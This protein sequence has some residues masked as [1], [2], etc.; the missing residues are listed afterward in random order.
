M[1][2]DDFKKI[3]IEAM[4]NHDKDTVTALNAV[5]NKL[6]MESIE[7]KALNQEMTEA[8]TTKILQ[9]TINELIEEKEGFIKAG[10]SDTVESLEKQIEAVK[11]YLPKLLTKEEIK[12]IILKLEDKSVPFVMK[13]FKA[14]YN[15]KVDM[16]LVSET[17]KE[18]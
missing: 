16:K 13:H 2:I 8:D 11:K 15:G 14:E 9:K 12:D 1:N 6:M 10:R 5:I 18:I 4:K 17:L 3:K 7:K